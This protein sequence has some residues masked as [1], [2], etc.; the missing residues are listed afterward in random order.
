MA[1]A[2]LRENGGDKFEAYSAGLEPGEINPYVKKVMD[3]KHID[4]S[5]QYSKD[6]T[7]YMG[8]IH[9]G[10][11]ITVCSNAEKRCPAV[12]PGVGERLHWPFEDPAAFVGS[13]EATLKKFREIRDQIERKIK[14][15]IS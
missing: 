6:V 13:E 15:W 14:F 2:F 12:F 10:Y 11:L 8:K 1:E 5:G 7:E 9:F 3:E 4:L